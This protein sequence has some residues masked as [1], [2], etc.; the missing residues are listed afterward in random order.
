MNRS[1]LIKDVMASGLSYR[2][3]RKAVRASVEAMILA[4]VDGEDIELPFGTIHP[5]KNRG[6]IRAWRLNKI[7]VINKAKYRYLFKQRDPW[8]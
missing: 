1:T 5:V 8:I 4:A 7:T 6:P 2:E 3:A